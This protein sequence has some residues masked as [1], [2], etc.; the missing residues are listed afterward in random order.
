MFVHQ[1]QSLLLAWSNN[2]LTLLVGR[3][4]AELA[5]V[6]RAF[7]WKELQMAEAGNPR[8]VW[9]QFTVDDLCGGQEDM[10]MA[11]PL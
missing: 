5:P 9:E 4:W 6:V 2:S 7:R 3:I 8:C 10:G 11:L 1:L